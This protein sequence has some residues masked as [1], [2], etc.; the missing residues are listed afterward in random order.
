[1][2]DRKEGSNMKTI[3]EVISNP[4][5]NFKGKGK[6]KFKNGQEFESDYSIQMLWNGQIVGELDIHSD[7]FKSIRE[8]QGEIPYFTLIGVVSSDNNRPIR[9]EDCYLTGSSSSSGVSGSW[10]NGRFQCR[11]VI[12]DP[13]NIKKKPQNE[14]IIQFGVVNMEQ[15][16]SVIVDTIMGKIWVRHC[17]G[18]DNLVKLMRL[19]DMSLITSYP[20]IHFKPDDTQDLEA[21]MERAIELMRDFLKITS[22]S[23][24]CWHEWVCVHAYE[25]A[26]LEANEY[27]HL[28]LRLRAPKT[29]SPRTRGVTNLA[30][31]ATFLRT[32]WKGYSKELDEKY[33]F[34]LALEWYIESNSATVIELRF[35]MATTCFEMLMDRFHTQMGTEFV[36]NEKL[37]NKFYHDLRDF[38]SNWMKEN[39]LPADVRASIYRSLKG[40]NRRQYVE[41]AQMLLDH[42]GITHSDTGITL[43]DIVKIRNN[44]THRGRHDSGNDRESFD[45]IVNAYEG[46]FA[47]LT[48]V[49]LSMLGYEGQYYDTTKGDW[50]DFA[51]VCTRAK[52]R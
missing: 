22:L 32:A 16:F 8:F 24:T 1:M 29:K 41:K 14:M 33:A 7:D 20:E 44:I 23:Q 34:D 21:I 42:W 11:E 15:T 28:F 12:L 38:S 51:S 52:N 27:E 43:E 31:S 9:A 36:L 3:S 19:Y 49:F 48:R 45:E 30:H 39:T 40:I 10:L 17:E 26:T 18:I 35:L 47:I 6:I 2:P 5:F 13:D 50:I 46:L 37:F 4:L 25:K